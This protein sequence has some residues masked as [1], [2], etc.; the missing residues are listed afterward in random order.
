MCFLASH[1]STNTN[2]LSKATDYFS[3]LLLQR[4]EAKVRRKEKS[5]KPGI[6]LFIIYITNINI[7]NVLINTIYKCSM[8][9]NKSSS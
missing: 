2:F 4:W 3:H 9:K 7:D 6:E 1:T 8:N 5:P